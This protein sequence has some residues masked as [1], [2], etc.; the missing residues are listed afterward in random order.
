MSKKPHPPIGVIINNDDALLVKPPK[1][2]NAREKIVGNIMASKRYT[3]RSATIDITLKFI[4][5]KAQQR[6]APNPQTV[7]TSCGR[8]CFIM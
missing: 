7:K 4:S 1:F 3:P 8:M 2:C 6:D 5:T